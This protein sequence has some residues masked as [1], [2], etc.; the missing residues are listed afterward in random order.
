[1]FTK[2]YTYNTPKERLRK[3]SRINIGPLSYK[4]A[5]GS[6]CAFHMAPAE[7]KFVALHF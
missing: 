6:G 4:K 7:V 2:L 3:E 5:Q 1:M